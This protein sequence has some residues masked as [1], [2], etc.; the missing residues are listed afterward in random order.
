[1]PE[2]LRALITEAGMKQTE[3]AVVIGVSDAT[4]S[5]MFDENGRELT[6]TEATAL[7]AE[8]QKRLGRKRGL[9]LNDVFGKAA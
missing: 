6:V 8:L 1:M 9:T 5:R 3:I 7:L 2:T 4:V